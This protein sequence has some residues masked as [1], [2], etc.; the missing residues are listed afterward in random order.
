M[1]NNYSSIS[2]FGS[3]TGMTG[4]NNPLTYVMNNTLDN[5]FLHGGQL[6][7]LGGGQNSNNGQLFLSDYCAQG[8]DNYCEYASHNIDKRF[9]S[10][11]EIT[12]CN[13]ESILTQ[14][15]TTGE[16][17]LRNTASRKYLVKMINGVEVWEPFDPTVA[18]SPMIRKWCP[19]ATHPDM[20]P[21]YSVNPN[22]IDNDIVMDKILANPKIATD[23]LKNIYDTMQKNNTFNQLS[24]TKLGQFYSKNKHFF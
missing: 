10:T 18:N 16:I 1:H 22:E 9:P 2:K 24:G 15:L 12:G 11:M 4:V 5:I 13:N 8:W 19:I 14:D 3:D 23:I 21:I 20:K 6:N 17:L 7:M